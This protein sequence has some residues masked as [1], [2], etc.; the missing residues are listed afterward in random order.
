MALLICHLSLLAAQGVAMPQAHQLTYYCNRGCSYLFRMSYPEA[1]ATIVMSSQK[2][3]PVA[4]TVVS[5]IAKGTAAIG[6]LVIPCVIGQ[7]SQIF[8]GAA[9]SPL[10]AKKVTTAG[11]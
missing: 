11:S 3:A 2:S 1:V 5:N 10:F 6:L 7:I 8:I 9:L 4:V